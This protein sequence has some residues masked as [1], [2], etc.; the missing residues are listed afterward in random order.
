VT[1]AAQGIAP[2]VS[3]LDAGDSCAA[4][5]PPVKSSTKSVHRGGTTLAATTH[6][7]ETHEPVAVVSEL[8][9]ATSVVRQAA[10]APKEVYVKA[11][12][13]NAA[14]NEAMRAAFARELEIKEDF[15][16]LPNDEAGEWQRAFLLKI[17]YAPKDGC[18]GVI[19]VSLYD[20]H[21]KL[22]NSDNKDCHEFP[23]GA[24][25]EEASRQL[26]AS[27]VKPL[28]SPQNHSMESNEAK[29]TASEERVK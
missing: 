8:A 3:H 7:Q 4:F 23:A 17:S 12:G 1:Q 2:D 26:V 6:A 25:L 9:A 29:G 13:G 20:E 19:T 27:V 18:Y 14:L 16:V 24:V 15:K 21:G 11:D 22:I 28:K 10:E 5:T